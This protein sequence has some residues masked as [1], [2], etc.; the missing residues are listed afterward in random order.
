MTIATMLRSLALLAAV[1]LAAACSTPYRTHYASPVDPEVSRGWRVADVVVSVPDELTVSE[2]KSL[3]PKADIVWR[4]D[5]PGDRK[6]Q[7]AAI[8]DEAITR[9]ASGL[10]GPRPVRF[11]VTVERFHALTFE[12]EARLADAGVHNI[13]FLI[14]VVD[15][16]TGESLRGPERI[17]AETPAFSGYEAVRRRLAGETQKSVIS[18]HVAATIAGWLGIGPDQRGTFTRLGD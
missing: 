16:R 15:A 10:R 2:Q 8:L 7:I 11:L 3:V 18:N 14:E 9:G 4:E 12:A 1:S 6:A 17:L 5:P 13:R